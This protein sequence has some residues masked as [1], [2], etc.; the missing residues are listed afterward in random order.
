M[1][2]SNNTNQFHK[3]DVG[4]VPA[5]QD[6]VEFVVHTKHTCDVCFQQPIVGRRYTS[7]DHSNYDLC[8]RCF[9]AYSGPEIGLTEAVLARDKK[10]SREFVLKLKIDNGRDVQ[11]R[12]IN[13]TEI[14]GKSVAQLSFGKMMSIASNYAFPK[15]KVDD[16]SVLD[17]FIAKAK[18]TYLDDDG[19]KITMTSNKELE[20]SFLQVLKNFPAHKPFR[21]TVTVPRDEPSKLCVSTAWKA[22]G[23]M[24]KRAE[25]KKIEQSPIVAE[26]KSKTTLGVPLQKL[27]KDFFIHARHTCDGCSKS[28]IIGTRYHATK[29]PDFDLCEAC[30]EKYEGED[31]DFKPEIHDRDRRM[32]QKWLKK[33]LRGSLKMPGNIAGMWNKANGDISDFLK[34]VQESGGSIESATVY[35]CPP[36]GVVSAP[37]LENSGES[38]AVEKAAEEVKGEEV[39]GSPK[40]TEVSDVKEAGGMESLPTPKLET[41]TVENEPS[42]SSASHDESFL[43]DA[44]GNG[45][46]AEAIGRTLDVCVQAIEE[47]MVDELQEVG[48]VCDAGHKKTPPKSPDSKATADEDVA[49]AAAVAADA[50]S[51]A[52]SMVSSMSDILKKIDDA[53][54]LDD[55]SR[56]DLLETNDAD[57]VVASIDVPSVVTGATI[58]KSE[59]GTE[60]QVEMPKVEDASEGEDEWS[61]ISDD[62]VNTKQDEIMAR[63]ENDN[64]DRSLLST[65]PLSPFLLAKWDTELIQL[66]ELGFL[67]DRKN[68]DVLERLEASHMGVDSIEKVTVQNAVEHLLA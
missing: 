42:S 32:Q 50:F 62:K 7:T 61:V 29:I 23:G 48:K 9:D 36:A 57:D 67:D 56:V 45:S 30:F 20:D 12:R 18:V 49:A 39:K 19:D 38:P 26:G 40:E 31:L 37:E 33:Q 51:V 10:R 55:G 59:D 65:E 4:N 3:T 15:N 66:H 34:K 2:E 24:N 28:P 27:E 58:L 1:S 11:V 60:K 25:Q 41:P 46:I 68:F 53:K 16:E 44:D 14:W 5:A 6:E 54:K 8:A 17:A 22:A 64:S 43:S 35:A 52:S 13:V 21:I 63:K 47:A